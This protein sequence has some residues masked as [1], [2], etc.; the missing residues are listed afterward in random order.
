VLAKTVS[1]LLIGASTFQLE[2]KENGEEA[3][4]ISREFFHF[5]WRQN[6][7]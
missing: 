3:K 5:V 7:A 1:L 2:R 6:P 4:K